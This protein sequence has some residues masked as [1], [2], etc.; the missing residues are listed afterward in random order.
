MTSGATISDCG[1]YRY[2][3]WRHWNADPS[4]LFIMLNPSTASA[5]EDDATIRRCVGFARSWGAG[6]IEVV[7]LFALR[8]TNPDELRHHEDPIGP[9]N[10]EA[11]F[12]AIARTSIVVGAWG[13]R[14]A[15]K[16]RDLVV[17]EMVLA[18]GRE[19]FA[20]R[21]TRDGFPEHP[22]RLPKH[23]EPVPYWSRMS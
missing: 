9:V 4:V 22:L 10:N 23:L 20:L 7:N 1:T 12:D 15:F 14:G 8:A 18:A 21:R 13:T 5:T 6:G 11:I 16:G 17:H 2:R 3:L 19:L